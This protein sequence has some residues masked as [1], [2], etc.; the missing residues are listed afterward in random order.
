M[1]IGPAAITALLSTFCALQASARSLPEALVDLYHHQ[2]H[3][4]DR[5]IHVDAGSLRRKFRRAPKVTNTVVRASPAVIARSSSPG[6]PTFDPAILNHELYRA[7]EVLEDLNASDA[8]IPATKQSIKDSQVDPETWDTQTKAACESALLKL[9]GRASN[10]SGMAICY[11]LPVLDRSTGVFKADMRLYRVCPPA[12]GW[13]TLI[14]QTVSVGLYYPGATVAIQDTP[15]TKRDGLSHSEQRTEPTSAAELNRRAG[16]VLV[17][18]MLQ[19]INL[20]GQ[21]N[22]DKMGEMAKE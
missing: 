10:P 22:G 8:A 21:I 15:R 6:V 12:P 3:R 20:V 5:T 9:K 18:Q 19:S 11:N 1:Y 16:E 14:D 4:V 7:G 2:Q 17:P 13:S